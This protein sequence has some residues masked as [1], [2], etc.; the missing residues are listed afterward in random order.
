MSQG[1][2]HSSIKQGTGLLGYIYEHIDLVKI[3]IFCQNI[4]RSL[5]RANDVG[6]W[7]ASKSVWDYRVIGWGGM[8]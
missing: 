7:F 4:S 1:Y 5:P 2:I 6:Q 8:D 3:D